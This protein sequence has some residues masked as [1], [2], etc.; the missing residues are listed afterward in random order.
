MNLNWRKLGFAR[1]LTTKNDKASYEIPADLLH[2]TSFKRLAQK[3][4]SELELVD[5]HHLTDFYELVGGKVHEENNMEEKLSF[6]LVDED[7]GFKDSDF[8][9]G[10]TR[11]R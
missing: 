2:K 7:N 4:L 1:S 5:V 3:S 6:T 11:L 10:Y 9:N 8:V